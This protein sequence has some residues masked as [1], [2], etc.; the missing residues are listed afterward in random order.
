[1][2]TMAGSQNNE[3]IPCSEFK[4]SMVTYTEVLRILV[5][6]CF[7]QNVCGRFLQLFSFLVDKDLK[8]L[9]THA[10]ATA[11]V[12]YC[13]EKTDPE[14]IVLAASMRVLF[15]LSATPYCSGG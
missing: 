1:M 10:V 7:M 8:A 13:F 2:L 5:L 3:R 9:E 12:Q 11:L 6:Q 15:Y 14:S 4:D